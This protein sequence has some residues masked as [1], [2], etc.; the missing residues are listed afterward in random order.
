MRFKSYFSL[1]VCAGVFCSNYSFA[2]NQ[3]GSSSTSPGGFT[4]FSSTAANPPM[5]QLPAS[6]ELK[7]QENED[8]LLS[9]SV[10]QHK[11]HGNWQSYFSPAQK[12]D[13]GRL[14]K[15]VPDGLWQVWYPNGQLKAVRNYSASLFFSVKQDVDLNHPKISRFAIT[16]RFKKEGNAVLKIF[17]AAYSFSHSVPANANSPV[18]LVKQNRN[19]EQYH[20]PF[21][22]SLHHGLFM[23]YFENGVVKDSGYYKEGLKDRMWVHRKTAN[24]GLWKGSYKNGV[25]HKE[26]KYYNASG[27]LLLIVFYT[28][29]GK[30]EWRKEM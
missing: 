5:F 16:D 9:A 10:R 4:I 23:N 3:K 21:N 15:G 7:E 8:L 14:V 25:K 18:E 13:E 12:I 22:N 6:G 30:E 20:P 2:Q 28:G 29:D 17:Y 26:W 24:S 27:K 1:F 11:L 19:K